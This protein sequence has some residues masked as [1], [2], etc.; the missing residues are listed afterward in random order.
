MAKISDM[1]PRE[2]ADRMYSMYMAAHENFDPEKHGDHPSQAFKNWAD[3]A[4]TGGAN[5]EEQIQSQDD[6][7]EEEGLIDGEDGFYG[8]EAGSTKLGITTGGLK[9]KSGGG[10][11]AAAGAAHRAAAKVAAAKVAATPLTCPY[12]T[13]QAARQEGHQQTGGVPVGQDGRFEISAMDGVP[14]FYTRNAVLVGDAALAAHARQGAARSVRARWRMR[15]KGIAENE[16][17]GRQGC[18]RAHE[19]SRTRPARVHPQGTAA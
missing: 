17:T 11:S 10:S 19:E 2:A 18:R 7:Q 13:V 12:R 5:S 6:M 9:K 3:I 15:S 14:R 1:D 8:V 16:R 4:A